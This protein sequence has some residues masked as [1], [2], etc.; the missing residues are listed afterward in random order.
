MSAPVPFRLDQTKNMPNF[1]PQVYYRDTYGFDDRKSESDND[2][3]T[4]KSTVTVRTTYNINPN[5]T[6]SGGIAINPTYQHI[7]RNMETSKM[8]NFSNSYHVEQLVTSKIL[9]PNPRT[10]LICTLIAFASAVQLLMFSMIA[11][12][13]DGPLPWTVIISFLLI[14]NTLIVLVFTR[15]RPTR[16]WLFASLI[17][18]AFSFIECAGLFFWTALLISDEEKYLEKVGANDNRI[19]TSTRIAMYSCQLI[20]APIHM[21]ATGL[22]FFILRKQI[23]STDQIVNGYFLSEPQLGH[24]KIL[25][26]I[27]LRQIRDLS[28]DDADNA[29]VGV[30]TG[31]SRHN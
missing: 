12:F 29:S 3:V 9:T 22:L 5:A 11:M 23:S 2:S 6:S 21:I 26:P 15:C 24:Q 10:L 17:A 28:D 31:G 8:T 14:L 13:Y 7:H 4:T 19:V 27:E 25:V 16:A 18:V 20:F 1:P 30:Q